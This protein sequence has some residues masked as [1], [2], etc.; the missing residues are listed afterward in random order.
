MFVVGR[1]AVVLARTKGHVSCGG[2]MSAS[3]GRQ[4]NAQLVN[5]MQVTPT[6]KEKKYQSQ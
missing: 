2:A 1:P 5:R 3:Y 4:T 6:T